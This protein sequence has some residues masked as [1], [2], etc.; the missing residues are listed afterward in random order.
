MSNDVDIVDRGPIGGGCLK[1]GSV[2]YSLECGQEKI[3]YLLEF[4]SVENL[5]HHS[6][7]LEPFLDEGPKNV[8]AFLTECS[9][10]PQK[11]PNK[12]LPSPAKESISLRSSVG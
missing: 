3:W 9:P 5:S 12:R 10:C 6:E 4:I 8:D 1:T 2:L 11:T 7:E